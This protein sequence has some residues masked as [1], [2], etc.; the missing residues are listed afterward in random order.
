MSGPR[1]SASMRATVRARANSCCEYCGIPEFG[2]LFGHEPDHIIAKQHG[3]E[4]TLENLALACMQC[5]RCKGPNIASVDREKKRIVPLFNPRTDRWS[6][7]FRAEGGRI[8]PLTAVGRATAALLE[9]NRPE[10]EEAR[11]NLR[12][13]GRWV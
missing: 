10:R 5:N 11:Q 12:L 7:H 3:G 8:T 6:E 13:S 2:T 4:T 1:I 9:C